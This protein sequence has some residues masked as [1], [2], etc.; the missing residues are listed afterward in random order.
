VSDEL[1][2]TVTA[3]EARV[4][5]SELAMLL[6][7][8]DDR[9]NAVV[10]IHAGAGGT[11]AQDWVEML[12][13]QYV[14]Y[15]ESKGF[16]ASVVDSLEGEEAGLK[17]IT[18]E[19]EGEY[20]YGIFSAERAVHR[21]VRIS[22]FDAAKRRH[23]S[24]ASLDVFPE[25]DEEVEIEVRDEDIRIDTYRSSGH[26]GQHI[27]VTDSAVRITHLA[28]GLV[29]QCQNE[30]SQHRNK[31]KAMAV[32]K[33]RLYQLRLD[34]LKKKQDIENAAKGEISFGNQI[35]SYVLA[36]YQLV[37]DHRTGYE[38]GDPDRVLNGDL[39]GFVKAWLLVKK[40]G[41]LPPRGTT[42]QDDDI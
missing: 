10:T 22:P 41:T 3:L 25:V 34:E 37:K 9:R 13:R 20:A 21:L 5:A 24:F 19:I 16:K 7:G 12:A 30:R 11:E 33:A 40:K 6:G 28:T 27:N 39:D 35:R 26:G 23:T 36:P 32:L 42:K 14:R 29:A 15:A 2:K 17:S 31:D 4:R 1:V 38:V 18:F 8:A